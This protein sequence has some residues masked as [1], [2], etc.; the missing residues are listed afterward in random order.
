[1]DLLEAIGC[2][3]ALVHAW[4]F[5]DNPLSLLPLWLSLPSVQ[6]RIADRW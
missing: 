6:V 5:E 4:L 3:P 2:S 1:M